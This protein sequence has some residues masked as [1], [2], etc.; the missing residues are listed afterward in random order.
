M[1][2]QNKTI[3]T[4][5]NWFNILTNVRQGTCRVLFWGMAKQ[6]TALYWYIML[7]K[8]LKRMKNSE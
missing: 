8:D 7:E 6:F 1:K 3:A 4:A 5:G 2:K